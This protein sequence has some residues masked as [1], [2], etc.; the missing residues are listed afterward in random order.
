MSDNPEPKHI[1][2]IGEF[3]FPMNAKLMLEEIK[4]EQAFDEIY[5]ALQQRVFS[6]TAIPRR[7]FSS[8]PGPSEF[9]ARLFEKQRRRQ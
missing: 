5:K 7:F 8:N 1:T 6:R 2:D 9:V 3:L 4:A